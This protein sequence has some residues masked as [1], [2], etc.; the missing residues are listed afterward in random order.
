MGL[1]GPLTCIGQVASLNCQRQDKH[2]YWN[3]PHIQSNV[4]KGL[5]HRDLWYCVVKHGIS[6][7]KLNRSLSV[8]FISVNRKTLEQMQERINWIVVIRNLYM[9]IFRLE[10]VR[11]PRTS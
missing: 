10:P 8:C 9:T 6:R 7:K 1:T 3:G 2:R 5:T 11:K 4:C